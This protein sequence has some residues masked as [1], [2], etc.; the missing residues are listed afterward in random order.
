MFLYATLLP[1]LCLFFIFF[2]DIRTETNDMFT[3]NT[4]YINGSVTLNV[5]T[6]DDT[7]TA[8]V[9]LAVITNVY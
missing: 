1:V 2:L 7:K 8:Q 9:H 5:S 4:V 6:W 3:I